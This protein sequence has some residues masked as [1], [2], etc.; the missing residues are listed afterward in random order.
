MTDIYLFFFFFQKMTANYSP[1]SIP[2]KNNN[3]PHVVI[4]TYTL[5]NSV[6]WH[7]SSRVDSTDYKILK[8]V[9]SPQIKLVS[10][11]LNFTKKTPWGGDSCVV[12]NRYIIVHVNNRDSHVVLIVKLRNLMSMVTWLPIKLDQNQS[13]CW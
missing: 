9:K 10:L 11:K 6:N 5:V 12:T 4:K 3:T 13:R 7:S 1:Q 8:S 2:I